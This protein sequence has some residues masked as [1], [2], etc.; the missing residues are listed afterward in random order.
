MSDSKSR[1]VTFRK[2]LRAHG[3]GKVW[4]GRLQGL[5]RERGKVWAEKW[6]S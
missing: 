2:G 5:G 4:R 1:G 6:G 3:T